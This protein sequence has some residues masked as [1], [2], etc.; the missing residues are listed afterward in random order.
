MTSVGEL[1]TLSTCPASCSTEACTGEGV[2]PSTWNPTTCTAGLGPAPAPAC[3]N[4]S[5]RRR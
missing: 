4:R 2:A 5:A 1:A 3:T